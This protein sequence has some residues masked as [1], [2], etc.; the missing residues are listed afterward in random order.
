MVPKLSAIPTALKD[1][2]DGWVGGFAD[3]KSQYSYPRTSPDLSDLPIMHN[4]DN[5]DKLERMQRALWPEFS[6]LSVPGDESSRIYQQFAPDI[7]R[8][9]YTNE[10]RVYSIICPQQGTATSFLGNMNLEV[11]V[12]GVRGWVNEDEKS[13][14]A[15]MIVEVAIWFG[16][17]ARELP[18]LKAL[19]EVA[20]HKNFPFSKENAII[21]EANKQNDSLNPIFELRTGSETDFEIP[22]SR[23]HSDEAYGVCHLYAQIGDIVQTHDKK[24]DHFNKVIVQ[25]L[26]LYKGNLVKKNNVLSW[27]IWLGEP[28]IVDKDEWQA[29]ADLWRKSYDIDHCA[30]TADGYKNIH[31]DQNYLDGGLFHPKSNAAHE[32]ARLIHLFV[33]KWTEKGEK[34]LKSVGGHVLDTVRNIFHAGKK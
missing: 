21:I 23:D 11:T 2:P 26:N 24:V 18:L 20:E 30:P 14:Y 7:S 29:H 5:I 1:I 12:K 8:I 27:N 32:E 6:W 4:M 3:S 31:D 28:E 34:K 33:E 19:M 17:D 22:P 15:D 16:K 10:G 9:G 25:I 13:V